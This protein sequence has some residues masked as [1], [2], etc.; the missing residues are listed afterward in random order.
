MTDFVQRNWLTKKSVSKVFPVDLTGWR[1]GEDVEDLHPDLREVKVV[2]VPE[3]IWRKKTGLFGIGPEALGA[4]YGPMDHHLKLIPGD[5]GNLPWIEIRAGSVN[6]QMTVK[7]LHHEMRHHAQQLLSSMQGQPWK[8]A[9]TPAVGRQVSWANEDVDVANWDR[10]LRWTTDPFEF[11]SQLSDI[12]SMAA[13][14]LTLAYMR[15]IK[16]WK[17]MVRGSI[18]YESGLEAILGLVRE[19]AAPLVPA[20]PLPT[21]TDFFNQSFFPVLARLESLKKYD[22][23]R[24]R[25]MISEVYTQAREVFLENVAL[26]G[27]SREE[28]EAYVVEADRVAVREA[29]LLQKH[30]QSL[31]TEEARRKRAAMKA[32]RGRRRREDTFRR[33]HGM[34]WAEAR[35]KGLL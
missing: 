3:S 28:A 2:V 9:G 23:V 27:T 18:Q 4:Y 16:R 26:I 25:K 12:V 13:R 24:Y 30:Q 7:V 34:G 19:E 21:P 35:K 5:P 22:P 14:R 6:L 20:P 29:S 17:P 15:L 1:Y 11:Y 10:R 31:T 33:L 32:A 8:G